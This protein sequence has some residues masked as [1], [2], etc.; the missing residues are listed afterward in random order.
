MIFTGYQFGEAYRE[1]RDNCC[2]YI[3]ATEVGGT[4]PALVEAMAYGNCILAN[5][6]PEH[7]E[8]L[9]GAG[10]YYRRND[11]EHLACKLQHLLSHP[12]EAAAYSV[13][14]QERAARLFSWERICDQ[15]E[16]LMLDAAR[17][18]TGAEGGDGN[19]GTDTTTER[20]APRT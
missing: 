10:L 2:V 6:T 8:V 12:D 7:F 3:Q 11:F 19:C 1:L 4:H 16:D 18:G 17:K 9:G 13:L 14:A 5:S 20:I 15:Y